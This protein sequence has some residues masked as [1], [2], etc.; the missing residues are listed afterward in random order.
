MKLPFKTLLTIDFETAWDRK[1]GFSLSKQTME[2]Y[3][4]DER[5]KVWGACI[6]EFGT[7]KIT[8]WYR[9]D[10]LSRILSTYD[11]STTAV[12]GQNTMF[13]GAILNWHYGVK[14]CMLL[15]TLCMARAVR[16]VEAGNSLA[17]LAQDLGLP[18]KGTALESSEGYLDELPPDVE[19]ALADYC[20]HDVWLTERVFENFIGEFTS[21]ELRLIDMT[22]RM[23]TE[24]ELLLDADMLVHA[25]DEEREM[26]EGLL[27]RLGVTDGDLASNDRFAVLLQSLGVEPPTKAKRPTKKTPNPVGYNWAFA[28]NDAMFQAMLNGDN[29]DVSMLCEA[30]LK[31]KSTTERTR[32]QRFYEIS[33]RGALPV[34]LTYYGARSG[35]WTAAKGSA[36]NMQNLKRGSFLR[37]AIMA[38][39]G[40][41]LVVGDLSQ[42]EPRVLAW[43][44]DYHDMLD[45]FRAGGDPYAA[46]GGQMFN[47]PGMTKDTHPIHRQS[48][49]AALL[50]CFGPDTQVLTQ[51]GWLP[52]VQVQVT[53]TVWDGQAWVQ[54]QG[55]VP[56]GE[57]QVLTAHGVSATSDHEIL[58][59]RGWVEWCEV[60]ANPSLL[61]SA[62]SLA[63]SLACDGSVAAAPEG[64]AATNHTCAARVVGRGLSTET[65]SPGEGQHAVTVAPS[66][67]LSRH[68]GSDGGTLP[69]ALTGNTETGCSIE[70][71]PSSYAARTLTA[72]STQ[73]TVGAVSQFIQ[74]GLKTVSSFFGTLFHSTVGTSPIC[75]SIAQTTTEGTNP[76]TYALS[77]AASTCR[78]NAASPQERSRHSSSASQPL[79]RRMQTYDIAY[80]G[81]RN[82]YTILTDEGPLIVHNCGYGLGWASFAAQLLVGFLGAPP[83][84]YTKKD[85]KQLGVNMLHIK[86]FLDYKPYVERMMEIPHICTTEELVVHCVVAKAIIDKYRDTAQPVVDLWNLCGKLIE[87]SLYGGEEYE[88]KCLTF[89]KEEIILPNGM[90]ICYPGLHPEENEDG[91]LEWV[92]GKD[93][94]KLYSGKVVNN[95]L[96]EGTEVL[97]ARGWVPIEK[98][99]VSD[100]VHDGVE[101]VQHSGI[102]FNGVQECLQLDGV[103]MTPDHKVLCEEGWLHASQVQRPYRPSLRGVDCAATD[104]FS[105]GGVV[106]AVPVPVRWGGGEARIGRDERPTSGESV[107]LR[108]YDGAV[109][110]RE[111]QKTRA[112]ETSVIHRVAE[113]DVP[114]L[115]AVARGVQK[116]RR[117]WGNGVRAVAHVRDVLRR[118]VRHIQTGAFLGAQGQQRGVFQGELLLGDLR[119]T[120]AEHPRHNTPCERTG[121]KREDRNRQNDAVLQA[122]TRLASGETRRPSRLPVYDITNCG[123]R[124]RFVVR[125]ASGPLVVHNCV[126]GTARIV[127]TDGMLRV[128]KRY[129]VKGTVHDELIA[130]APKE[131]APEALPWVLDRMTREPAY[132][133]G[134]PLAADGGVHRR[135]GLAKN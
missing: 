28:K 16:G 129:P 108:V 34:P 106:L 124:A 100:M 26:R 97:T 120:G 125:G 81:P 10:E 62:L 72:W 133:P 12:L 19:K 135:Y 130:L 76:A 112:V 64:R 99:Q 39:P 102:I 33:Q 89:R 44:S 88:Y 7:D 75:S 69:S 78:T 43:L 82:R 127:M 20:A 134:I 109:D 2:E 67:R 5:F 122:Q 85:A 52:I 29:E 117:A 41:V 31:V 3:L 8:Q 55:V 98:V 73:T 57:K 114:V 107:E 45:I 24:P 84:R 37:K 83:L 9:G 56:Q 18:D 17:K 87:T 49:K 94:T 86:R 60:L 6:H 59:E 25:L 113:H 80:A 96:A 21:K 123:P 111:E 11:W 131:E 115:Q 74:R 40:Q 22:L 54:H 110:R 70:S 13:D 23:Y 53:D 126:Q 91:A 79:K 65:T 47:I 103:F 42:I 14:P 119:A 121:A 132:L 63:S 27:S 93:R 35:R 116:L 118:H 61:K 51:R 58:T 101:F 36:I 71:A 105:E 4:R 48:A 38:P 104:T 92:Y 95:C 128:H 77:H 90:K 46:F 30:R 1:I 66:E 68:G 15:D 50:G 32:A